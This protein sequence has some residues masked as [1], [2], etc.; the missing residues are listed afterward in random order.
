MSLD[1]QQAKEF[2]AEWIAAWNAHDLERIL[3]HYHDD[4]TMR[5]PLIIQLMNEPSGALHGKAQIRPYWAK[6][7]AA[8]PPIQFELLDV[9]LGVNSLTIYYYSVGRVNV[10]ET[11]IFNEAGQITQGMAQYSVG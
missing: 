8:Q 4:F 11:L 5:S 2:D 10:A 1:M 7:L 6:G 9:L 3:S